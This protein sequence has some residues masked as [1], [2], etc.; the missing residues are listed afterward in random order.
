MTGPEPTPGQPAQPG[1]PLSAWL[2]WPLK[3]NPGPV[4]GPD[5]ASRSTM[6]PV[7]ECLATP[8]HIY[9]P[10]NLQGWLEGQ[11]PLEEGAVRVRCY[12]LQDEAQGFPWCWSVEIWR[13]TGPA[14]GVPAGKAWFSRSSTNPAEVAGLAHTA[15][16]ADF[17]E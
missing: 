13:G 9:R 6:A 8:G 2:G 10:E 3:K 17:Y 16:I 11:L 1:R 5:Q 15:I 12:R 14:A 7:P 4:S